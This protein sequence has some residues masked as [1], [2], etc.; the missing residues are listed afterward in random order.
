MTVFIG[1]SRSHSYSFP[2]AA[3]CSPSRRGRAGCHPEGFQPGNVGTAPD[4][5]SQPVSGAARKTLD[6]FNFLSFI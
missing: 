5:A 6:P 1:F 2:R 3:A 4:T